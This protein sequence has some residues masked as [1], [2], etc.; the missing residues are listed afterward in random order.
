MEREQFIV[1]MLVANHAGVLTRVSALFARRAFNIDSLTVG[2]TEDPA[3]SR[4]TIVSRGDEN[5]KNQIVRQLEKLV[6]V[7]KVQVLDAGRIVVR[8]L[9]LVKLH[10]NKS[11][12]SEIMEAVSAYRA[13]VVNLSPCSILI[14]ITGEPNKLNAFLEYVQPYG[15]IELCRTGPT[16]M[17]VDD[18]CLNGKHY[19]KEEADNG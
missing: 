15:I 16:A 3:V 7:K 18:Y 8:E 19:L 2:E 17:G 10:L 13:N 9:L 12:L 6:D 11:Q 1:S 14:K 5:V 4:M